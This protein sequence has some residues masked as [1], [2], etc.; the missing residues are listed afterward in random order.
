MKAIFLDRDGV[1]NPLIYNSEFGTVDSPLNSQQF[2][3]FPEA[4]KGISLINRLGIPAVLISN[5]PGIA[6]G[7]ISKSSF[8]QIDRKMKML[9]SARGAHLDAVYYCLHHPNAVDPNYRINCLCRKPEPGMLVK[10]ADEMGLDL[11]ESF[12]IGDGLTDIKAGNKVGCKTILI[13]KDKC[14]LCRKMDEIGLRPDYLA[15]NLWDAAKLAIGEWFDGN[16]YRFSQC[17]RNQDVA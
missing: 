7:K 3:L 15:A 8:G 17:Q 12:F 1:L 5:Q 4:I 6:K 16:I 9:L 13:G 2:E 11:K 10:A 14:N